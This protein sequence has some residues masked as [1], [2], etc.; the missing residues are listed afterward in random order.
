MAWNGIIFDCIQYWAERDFAVDRHH[1]AILSQ[2]IT[3]NGFL[4][5]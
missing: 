1:D 3:H 5:A 4:C 2:P